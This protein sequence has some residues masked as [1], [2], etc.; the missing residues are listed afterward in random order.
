[1]ICKYIFSIHGG[2]MKINKLPVMGHF[3]ARS[4]HSLKP[5]VTSQP[6]QNQLNFISVTSQPIY[7]YLLVGVCCP[8][9][10][11]LCCEFDLFYRSRSNTKL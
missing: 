3:T 9:G 4:L 5:S 8:R 10:F 6:I 1:M 11:D 2:I 7:T